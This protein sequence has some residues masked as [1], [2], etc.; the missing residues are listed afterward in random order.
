[1]TQ[2]SAVHRLR[3]SAPSLGSMRN[4]T[5]PTHP[6]AS[7]IHR[8]EAAARTRHLDRPISVHQQIRR[9]EVAVHDA[10]LVP[11]SGG[12]GQTNWW[13]WAGK[14]EA[15]MPWEQM[16]TNACPALPRCHPAP[17]HTNKWE[18]MDANGNK[19]PPS[20]APL[21]PSVAA[22]KQMGTNGSN[23]KQMP[24]QHCPAAARRRS[25]ETNGN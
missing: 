22:H 16:A 6:H 10:T 25:T 7:V 4:T 13:R 21:P 8:L 3:P 17:Q 24:V 15:G 19:C 20:P 18:Q 9:L 14:L 23:W 11:A 1:M 12:W 2:S 5:H